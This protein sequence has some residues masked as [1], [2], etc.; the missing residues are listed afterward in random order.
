MIDAARNA[1]E[2]LK[3]LGMLVGSEQTNAAKPSLTDRL[4]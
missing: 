3:E 4:R 2:Q 1:E